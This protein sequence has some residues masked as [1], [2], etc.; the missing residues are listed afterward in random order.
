[1][2]DLSHSP[3]A[4]DF[5]GTTLRP[6]DPGYDEARQVFNGMVDRRPELIMRCERTGR[7]RCRYSPWRAPKDCRSRCTAEGTASPARRWSTG[8]CAST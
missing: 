5:L 2:T 8:G 6:S 3:A 4:V 7:R 1:M